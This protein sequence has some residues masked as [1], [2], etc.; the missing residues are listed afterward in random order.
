MSPEHAGHLFLRTQDKG[1]LCAMSLGGSPEDEC[2]TQPAEEGLRTGP[3][4][5]K[6]RGR[7]GCLQA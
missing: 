3:W 7:L 1:R 2:A 4:P 5:T 6:P